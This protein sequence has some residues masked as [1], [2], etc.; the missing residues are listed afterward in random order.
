MPACLPPIRL[1]GLPGECMR[2][3]TSKISHEENIVIA[4]KQQVTALDLSVHPPY[5]CPPYGSSVKRA[6]LQALMPLPQTLSELTGP[7]YG[8]DNIHPLD[9]DLT[10][11]AI[12]NGEP[13]GERI[14]VTGRVLDEYDRPV[15]HAL[16]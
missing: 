16:I 6:P 10:R 4:S 2:N 8:E 15:P 5:L 12:K 3:W 14:I 11:N 9:N 1:S 13:I 7:V